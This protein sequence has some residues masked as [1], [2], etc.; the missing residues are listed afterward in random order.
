[1]EEFR[2]YKIY[3][4]TTDEFKKKLW[5]NEK[6]MDGLRSKGFSIHS[7]ADVVDAC[8]MAGEKDQITDL[9]DDISGYNGDLL[10]YAKN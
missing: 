10:D 9:I 2:S 7:S 8:L 3:T 4:A 5:D 6:V 1:V